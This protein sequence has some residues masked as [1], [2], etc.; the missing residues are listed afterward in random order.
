MCRAAR[1]VQS[2]VESVPG[3]HWERVQPV[4]P[5]KGG[6]GLSGIGTA[7]SGRG[8]EKANVRSPARQGLD[9]ARSARVS[10]QTA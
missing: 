4:L 6:P 3:W 8:R 1:M 9:K 10:Q 7:P 5:R 2:Q